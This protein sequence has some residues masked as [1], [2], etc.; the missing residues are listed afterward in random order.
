MMNRKVMEVVVQ[1]QFGGTLSRA[2]VEFNDQG[3]PERVFHFSYMLPDAKSVRSIGVLVEERKIF[4]YR[5]ENE[6][7]LFVACRYTDKGSHVYN[8]RAL[9]EEFGE[10]LPITM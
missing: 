6:D 1:S 10:D 8:A 2:L 3:E 7:R 5:Y 9:R 4:D